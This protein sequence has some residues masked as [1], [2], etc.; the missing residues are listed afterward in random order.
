MI[1]FGPQS[2]YVKSERKTHLSIL[3]NGDK[4]VNNTLTKNIEFR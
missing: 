4:Q 3:L 1:T 2:G